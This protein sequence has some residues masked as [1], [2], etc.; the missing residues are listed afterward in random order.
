MTRKTTAHGRKLARQKAQA[1]RGYTEYVRALASPV[2]QTVAKGKTALMREKFEALMRT[3][4]IRIYTADD[5]QPAQD[6]LATLGFTLGVGANIGL[7]IDAES[8]NARRMHAALRT[9]V[10]LSVDGGYWRHS[11]ATIL[12]EA[13]ELAKEAFIAYPFDG[14]DVFDAAEYLCSRIAQGTARMSDVAG[15]EIYNKIPDEAQPAGADS[16]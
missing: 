13:I 15:A 8:P 9:V 12:H 3:T 1:S 2:G 4:A 7:N 6:L 16:Y 14:A 10:Q 11:Q 5:G